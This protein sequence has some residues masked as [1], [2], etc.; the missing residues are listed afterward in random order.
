MAHLRPRRFRYAVYH[1]QQSI[2]S[3]IYPCQPENENLRGLAYNPNSPCSPCASSTRALREPVLPRDTLRAAAPALPNH[4]PGCHFSSIVPT[5]PSA[6][7]SLPRQVSRR[8]Y[9][10]MTKT[11]A[12]KIS[13]IHSEKLMASSSNS[14]RA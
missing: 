2:R 1:C 10:L 4:C 8:I 11:Q 6:S 13:T 9:T 12:G 14:A 3:M 5:N 7:A